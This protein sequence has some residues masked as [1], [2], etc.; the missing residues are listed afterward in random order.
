MASADVI[1]APSID[2]EWCRYSRL[3]SLCVPIEVRNPT[4]LRELAKIAKR[5]LKRETTLQELFPKYRYTRADWVREGLHLDQND[6]HIHR[7]A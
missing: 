7:I 3:V 4:D 2:A 5:L 6:L 1:I